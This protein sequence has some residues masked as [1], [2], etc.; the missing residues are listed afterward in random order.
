MNWYSTKIED[1]YKALNSDSKGL[2]TIESNK[3]LKVNGKNELPKAKK[4]SI[5]KIFLSE[6]KDSIVIVLLFASLFSFI[7]GETVDGFVILFIIFID[8]VMGTV[9]EWKVGKSVEALSNLIKV[10]IKVLRD[11]QEIEIDSINL[12]KGDV[13]LIESGDKIPA[14]LRII[15]SSN[16]T[17]DESSLTGESI[18]ISKE[19]NLLKEET[20]LAERKNMVF[21]GTLVITGRATCIV[22]E[23]GI[24]TEVG[25]IASKVKDVKEAPS[26][27]TVRMNK[28]SKQITVLIVIIAIIIALLL[29]YKGTDVT[30]IFLAVIALSVS[31]MPEGLPL[32]LTMA[33][34]I[35]ANR[36]AKKDVIVKKLNSVESLGS[37]TV[38]ASDKT[39]TLTVNEQ[40][41]KKIL[42]PNGNTYDIEGTGYNGN[43]SI[44]GPK[45][46]EIDDICLL[47]MINNEAG[48]KYEN[49]SWISYG[50]SIDIAFLA[51]SYKAHV[52]DSKIKRIESIPYESEKKYSALFYEVDGTKYVTV[53]GS[54]EKVLSMSSTMLVDGKNIPL[55]SK[56]LIKQNE[57]LAS[58]GYRVIALAKA[59][60]DKLKDLTFIGMVAFIDP[61]RKETI[62]SIKEC[63]TAGIK[64]VMITGDHP[65]TA[66]SIAKEL[67]IANEYFE[68]ATSDEVDKYFKLGPEEFDKFVATKTVFTR[69]T[70]I[71]KFEII[72]SYKRQKEFVAV[73]GDG[74]NDAPAIKSANIGIAMGSGTDF[75]KE[76]AK[77]II[78]DDDFMS[79]V[80]GI[81]EGRNAY[82]N[83]RK[84]S[85]MLLSCGI[86]EVLFFILSI[87]F[88]LP[89]PLVAIQLLWLNLVTDGL[90]DLAL[91]FEKSE[92]GI[93]KEKPRKTDESLFDKNLISET[94]FSGVLIGLIVFAT[95]VFL[96]KGLSFEI[97]VARGYIM[98]LM[99]F[100]QNIHVLNCRSEKHSAF[101]IPLKDNPLIV[102]SI[103]SA[104]VLQIIVMEV[105]LFSKFLQ[106]VSMPFEHIILMFVFALPVLLVLEIY[107]KVK[108]RR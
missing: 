89:M 10:K 65:L 43:G 95:W 85:F 48:L 33:L 69:V 58:L 96:I 45:L 19:N 82:S 68:V 17:I 97:S 14:D 3:R 49:E 39:G 94:L 47:G 32:A 27:L 12:V 44:A 21:A 1:V 57:E 91:S 75:A 18:A 50:D 52:N 83:I 61:I 54:I 60:G 74:V 30:E 35:G 64:V 36:M 101:S 70:P 81:K 77:M 104:I 23:T 106:T 38:I 13:V 86:S 4:D 5:I 28:F 80:D 76:T 25:K 7:A 26:P 16:L 9:Q 87:F 41:A 88:G 67:N 90:Q 100:L 40:T 102:F 42:L 8:I 103:V 24:N 93:M 15:E 79:I 99:V 11:N 72:E 37:C 63:K 108:Y 78:I 55:D 71:E 29:L 62:N 34:T 59:E 2:L 51:L 84:I 46:S 22:V 92:K 98:V 66:F 31:A 53:K 56:M 20:I 105:P 6:F 107:K 73:T